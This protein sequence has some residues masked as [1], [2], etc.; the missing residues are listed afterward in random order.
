MARR[1]AG[2]A[3]RTDTA[4][5]A[6]SSA[7]SAGTEPLTESEVMPVASTCAPVIRRVFLPA[8][9]SGRLVSPG[10]PELCGHCR[11]GT[12]SRLR[13]D[14]QGE[15]ASN[16]AARPSGSGISGRRGMRGPRC[17]YQGADSCGTKGGTMQTR[18]GKAPWTAARRSMVKSMYALYGV[19]Y[20]RGPAPEA[21]SRART[22][23]AG[24]TVS[25]V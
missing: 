10:P 14:D 12:P 5:P 19:S 11:I 16:R 20:F 17:G 21:G 4:H 24:G 22:Q 3:A 25:W 1:P 2:Q 7:R 8:G 13:G 15:P 23:Q 6:K 18:Q 9:G